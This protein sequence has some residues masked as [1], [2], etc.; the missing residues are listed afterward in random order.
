M[1][2]MGPRTAV[3]RPTAVG[4][5]QPVEVRNSPGL[6]GRDGWEAAIKAVQNLAVVT[7]SIQG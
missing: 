3:S 1:A 7:N 5:D 4:Q 6:N 2:G